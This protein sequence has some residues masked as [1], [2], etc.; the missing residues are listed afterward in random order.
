MVRGAE[1]VLEGVTW[2]AGVEVAIEVLPQLNLGS[3]PLVLKQYLLIK[4][5]L[6]VD[7]RSM[8]KLTVHLR[9]NMSLMR[10]PTQL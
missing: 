6:D 8:C 5:Y 2:L 3:S 4:T 9:L 10:S 7:G 1:E